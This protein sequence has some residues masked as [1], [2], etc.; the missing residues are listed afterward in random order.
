MGEIEQ[1]A[2]GYYCND[3]GDNNNTSRDNARD[4]SIS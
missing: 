4:H 2:C 3:N 1:A